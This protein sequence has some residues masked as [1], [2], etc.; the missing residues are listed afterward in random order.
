[1]EKLQPTQKL[2]A[3]TVKIVDIPGLTK[4]SSHG[5]GVGNQFLADIRNADALIHVVRCFDDE[6]LPHIE[7][8][9]DP[10]RDI[11]TIDLELQVKDL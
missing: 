7:G 6:N 11:E 5:Q 4:G 3:A 2:V 8:S 9:V 10:V 1:M